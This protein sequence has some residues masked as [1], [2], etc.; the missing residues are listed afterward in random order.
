[1]EKVFHGANTRGATQLNWLNSK[2]SF[3]FADYYCPERIKFGALR[4]LNDDIVKGGMGFGTHSHQNMEIISIPLKGA[5]KH[6][7]SSG[8]SEIIKVDDVQVMSAG[9]GIMHS[10]INASHADEVHFLQIWII[11][12]AE[13]VT[14]RYDQKSFSRIKNDFQML[15][16]PMGS[17]NNVLEI[18]QNAYVFRAQSEKGRTM[19][20]ALN[21]KGN[22][23]YFFV[24]DGELA[25]D[26]QILRS[27][28]GLGVSGVEVLE[29]KILSSSEFIALEVPMF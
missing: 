7:D 3:S 26:G 27:R 23:V 16:S 17:E 1:M 19:S 21:S 6:K 29:L 22:G 28:D 12:G 25:I 5:L 18:H 4:V 20:Y 15:V 8:H 9:K 2:H 24:I 10:E 13:G 11:P 14:P